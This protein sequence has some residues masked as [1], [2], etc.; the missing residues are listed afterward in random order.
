MIFLGT[1]D[2]APDFSALARC[3]AQCQECQGTSPNRTTG[4]D[5]K[6]T[7][8]NFSPMACSRSLHGSVML[9]IS[10]S[11]ARCRPPLW[12]NH[13]RIQP[14]HTVAGHANLKWEISE[15]KWTEDRQWAG[16][17]TSKK[18]YSVP[19]SQKP[20]GAMVRWPV[21]PRGSLRGSTNSRRGTAYLG[22]TSTGGR[23][24]PPRSAGGA[25]TRTKLGSTSLR[26]AL[27][28]GCNR[29][30]CGRRCSRRRRDGRAVEGPRPPGRREVQPGGTRLPRLYGCGKASDGRGRR[31][32]RGVGG[33]VAG[34]AEGAGAR[35]RGLRSRA[36]GG[37]HCFCPRPNSWRLQARARRIHLS[38]LESSPLIFP[39]CASYLLGT[40]LGGG[41]RGACNV[42]PPRGQRTAYIP[43]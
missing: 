17:R 19:K 10:F 35:E 3:F 37:N 33:G 5:G 27:S 23:T 38:F 32:E 7:M 25:G 42:P 13:T 29:R 18:K 1:H 15:K 39:W 24:G 14:I 11:S 26:S 31:S 22:G 21:A 43:G 2:I 40:G 9:A 6:I 8:P 12:F 30:S 41:Q 36:L 20:D 28:G 34:V 4:L 16:G